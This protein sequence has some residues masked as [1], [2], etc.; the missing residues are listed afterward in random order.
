[1]KHLLMTLICSISFSA[2]AVEMT[3]APT[4]D[5]KKAEAMQK[6]K[7]AKKMPIAEKREALKKKHAMKKAAKAKAA[8][9]TIASPEVSSVPGGGPEGAV[10]QDLQNEKKNEDKRENH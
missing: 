6:E 10:I 5:S 2:V 3:T 4:E 8:E 7:E 1:M 9:M